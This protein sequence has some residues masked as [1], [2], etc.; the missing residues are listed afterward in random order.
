MLM[1]MIGQHG[2]PT[3]HYQKPPLLICPCLCGI[4]PAG[5]GMNQASVP[6]RVSTF[7][8]GLHVASSLRKAHTCGAAY[9][10]QGVSSAWIVTFGVKCFQ[11]RVRRR[12]TEEFYPNLLCPCLMEFPVDN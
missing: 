2:N 12:R 6:K 5:F 8:E 11:D 7:P 10:E 9:V 4:I 3:T 1:V